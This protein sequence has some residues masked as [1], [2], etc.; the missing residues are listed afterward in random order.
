MREDKADLAYPI[1]LRAIL[2]IMGLLMMGK[3]ALGIKTS[4]ADA[5]VVSQFLHWSGLFGGLACLGLAFMRKRLPT[6]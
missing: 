2:I 4:D 3:F 5:S 1:W 6:N